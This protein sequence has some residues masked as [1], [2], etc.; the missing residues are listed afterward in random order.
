MKKPKRREWTW[1]R[2][3]KL[4]DSV[5]LL[6]SCSSYDPLFSTIAFLFSH[7]LILSASNVQS[8]TYWL[9][10]YFWKRPSPPLLSFISTPY[11][12]FLLLPLLLPLVRWA[13]SSYS[14]LDPM[15]LISLT[16]YLFAFWCLI[17]WGVV[18]LSQST[19]HWLSVYFKPLFTKG[20]LADY[21]SSFP[22]LH[23]TF[24]HRYS[25]PRQPVHCWPVSRSTGSLRYHN[26]SSIS[27]SLNTFRLLQPM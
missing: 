25:H 16:V 2:G 27:P 15:G 6:T 1:K 17:C 24:M 12:L 20:K 11:Q 8:G 5:W 7:T 13:K 26:Q 14:Q 3:V 9:L 19:K 4:T 21:L 10:F 22:A 18:H 23:I